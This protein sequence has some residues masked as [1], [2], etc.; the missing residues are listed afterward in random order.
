MAE[1]EEGFL[2]ASSSPFPPGTRR[3]FND[4]IWLKKGRDVDNLISE[5][6]SKDD[7]TSTKTSNV[8]AHEILLP[9]KSKTAVASSLGRENTHFG[10]VSR[11][12]T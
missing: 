5:R 11:T 6:F 3:S 2:E 7:A 8:G 10:V 4:E 1:I 12:A 9:V